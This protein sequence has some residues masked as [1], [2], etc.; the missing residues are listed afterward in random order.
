MFIISKLIHLFSTIPT[1]SDTQINTLNKQIYKFLW[2]GKPDKVSRN[3]I[4]LPYILGGLKMLNLNYFI[5]SIK[6]TWIRR[7]V[8]SESQPWALLFQTSVTTK[9]D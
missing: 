5:N 1:L 2:D 6:L 8:S 4:Q 9:T 3:K 7:L